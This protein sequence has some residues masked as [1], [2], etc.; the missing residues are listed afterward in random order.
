MIKMYKKL[1]FSLVSVCIF[2]YSH[3][4]LN[5][6]DDKVELMEPDPMTINFSSKE[7]RDKFYQEKLQQFLKKHPTP[8]TL[9]EK[10]DYAVQLI[11]N[12]EY[13][14]AIELL[15]EIEKKHPDLANTAVNLGT[16]YELLGQN[17]Q[18]KFWIEKGLKINPGVHYG[19]EW[20]HLN[21]L[22][23]K[24]HK[25]D[26][27]WLRDN[28]ILGL[29]FGTAYFPQSQNIH[30]S[31]NIDNMDDLAY[32]AKLQLRE[33]RKFIFGDDLMMS[34]L[35]YEAAN[36]EMLRGQ[37]HEQKYQY[38]F[39]NEIAYKLASIAKQHGLKTNHIEEKRLK[40]L[41]SDSFIYRVYLKVLD[42]IS[43]RF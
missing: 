34:C 4:C 29:D 33:R 16:A 18:A 7:Q 39:K 38:G 5:S 36:V 12:R 25:A 28:P 20:I 1:V 9:E 31:R 42:F 14:Q 41:L 6:Y 22:K 13:Q 11:Y 3:A 37:I 26:S 43:D 27:Q 23:A 21:I 10:N 19:S 24:L 32:E 35:A 2:N 15:L 30:V 40:M 8:N 17:E